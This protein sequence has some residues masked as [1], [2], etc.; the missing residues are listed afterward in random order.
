MVNGYRNQPVDVIC[1]VIDY[2]Y[3]NY[4]KLKDSEETIYSKI[5]NLIIEWNINGTK[6]AGSLTRD[7]MKLWKN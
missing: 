7:I 1:F 4:A 6:T 3:T 5:E 2:E